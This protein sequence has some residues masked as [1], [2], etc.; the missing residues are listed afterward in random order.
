MQRLVT[1]AVRI[2]KLYAYFLNV[3]YSLHIQSYLIIRE[4]IVFLYKNLA[5]SLV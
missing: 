2:P 4:L 5:T 3:C 1:V